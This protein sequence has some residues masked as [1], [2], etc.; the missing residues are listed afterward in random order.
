M[1][2]FFL[3]SAILVIVANFSLCFQFGSRRLLVS[4]S[5]KAPVGA[6]KMM[7]KTSSSSKTVP[8]TTFIE[9]ARLAARASR[10]AVDDGFRLLE[11]EFPPLPLEFLE[12]STSSARDIADAN[13][14]WA[15]E[16]S[17]S[18]TDLGQVSIIYPDQPELDDAVR[19]VDM[20]GGT[21][22]M[23]NVT[24]A[25]IRSDS[26]KNAGSIDQIFSSIFSAR[27][28]GTVEGI[29]NT[30][31]YIALISS[32]QELPDLEKLHELDPSVPIIFFNLRLD[33]LVREAPFNLRAYYLSDM[34][35]CG[36]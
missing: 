23:E 11:V 25:T 1:M 10:K 2:R 12:D 17:K 24:L 33:I 20:P 9:C 4:S 29:P 8:P 18:F 14:R 32:T 13:T 35:V 30:K 22:P 7:V 27:R 15:I 5:L 31:T 3:I 36:T 16:F 19:Y 6:L 26:I 28:G 21:N 34:Y